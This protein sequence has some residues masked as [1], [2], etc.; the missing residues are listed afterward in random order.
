M[1][2]CFVKLR[3]NGG[4]PPKIGISADKTRTRDGRCAFPWDRCSRPGGPSSDWTAY[5]RD[6]RS[7]EFG[8]IRFLR[9]R[10]PSFIGRVRACVGAAHSSPSQAEPDAEQEGIHAVRVRYTMALRGVLR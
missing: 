8:M 3:S 1:K 6:R 7:N 5:E 9:V 4:S 2:E 10:P